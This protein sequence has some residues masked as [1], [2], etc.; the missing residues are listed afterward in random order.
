MMTGQ[1]LGGQSP[2]AAATY[3]VMIFSSMCVSACSSFLIMSY[4]LLNRIFCWRSMRFRDSVSLSIKNKQSNFKETESELR[5]SDSTKRDSLALHKEEALPSLNEYSEVLLSIEN[6]V[7]ERLSAPISITLARGEKC[8]VSGKSGVG[9]TQ[10]LRSIAGLGKISNGTV[11]LNGKS[12]GMYSMNNWRSNVMWVSQDRPVMAGTPN[13]FYDEIMSYQSQIKNRKYSKTKVC[14]PSQIAANWFLGEEIFDR[15]W[16]TLS[17][18]EA[19]RASLSIALALQPSV[20]LLDEPTSAC[21]PITT[22][23]IEETLLQN[24]DI[25]IIVVSHDS[26]QLDRLCTTRLHL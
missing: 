18:G 1:I 17:G 8:G 21:D 3:Q 2:R 5:F 10:L 11:N 23:M 22:L 14:L 25:A 7:S 6:V 4:L 26:M 20:L 19:Q 16:N 15:P 9:K 12:M 24:N 13:E